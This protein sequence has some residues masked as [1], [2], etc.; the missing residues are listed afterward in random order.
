MH[1]THYSVLFAPLVLGACTTTVPCDRADWYQ[2]GRADG[3]S[4]AGSR[5]YEQYQD[6][7]AST[8]GASD[9]AQ[10]EAGH[11][12]G[13]ADWCEPRVVFNAARDGDDSIAACPDQQA[14]SF[15]QAWQLGLEAR[16]LRRE[17]AGINTRLTVATRARQS[18]QR[19]LERCRQALQ[20]TPAGSAEQATLLTDIVRL[21]E[22]D[23]ELAAEHQVLQAEQLATREELDKHKQNARQTL[24][25]LH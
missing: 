4:A 7:C 12:S 10:Y 23:A 11:A 9:R 17:L 5:R 20:T 18:V 14:E 2:M 13:V 21:E 24:A 8:P 25:R 16:E 22:A 1:R 6:Q 15:Q 19:K 3:Y